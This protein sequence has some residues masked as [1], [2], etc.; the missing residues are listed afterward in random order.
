[1]SSS[2]RVRD[3]EFFQFLWARLQEQ[4]SAAVKLPEGP[5]RDRAVAEADT[6]YYMIDQCERCGDAYI[7][8]RDAA[9]NLDVNQGAGPYEASGIQREAD[10]LHPLLNVLDGWARRRVAAFAAHPDYRREWGWHPKGTYPSAM[11]G[12]E[13]PWETT[14]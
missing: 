7:R 2:H 1:M 14:S 11:W 12:V 5:D 3:S 10:Y 6:D 13:P 8:N 4:T 9:A